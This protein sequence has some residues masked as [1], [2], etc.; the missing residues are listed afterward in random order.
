MVLKQY[1]LHDKVSQVPV[2]SYPVDYDGIGRRSIG[3]RTIITPDFMTG[4]IAI[5]GKDIPFTAIDA[6]RA[7]LG[8]QVSG[9]SRVSY[10]LTPKPP[11]TTEWE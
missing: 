4:R 9:I 1:D 5:P 8:S 6:M 3:V 2:I 11:A 7:A 10:D